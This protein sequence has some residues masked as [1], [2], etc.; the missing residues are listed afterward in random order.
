M[1]TKISLFHTLLVSLAF[2][3][4]FAGPVSA[5][6]AQKP[7]AVVADNV[8]VN[9]NK[10]D[11]KMLMQVN[12]MSAYKAHAIVA[13]RNKNGGFKAMSELSQ[14]KGFKRMKPEAIQAMGDKLVIE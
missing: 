1:K 13:Y 6:P 10:A 11:A 3:A 7:A 12:G 9:L 2:T 14:V 8:K 5:A 4:M